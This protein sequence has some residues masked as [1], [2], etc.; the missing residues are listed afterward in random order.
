M[1]G[2]LEPELRQKVI[3]EVEVRE[4]F[5]VGRSSVVAGSYVKSGQITR[6]SRIRLIREGNTIYEGRVASL[7]RFKDDVRE[8]QNGYECGVVL[9][10]FHDIQKDDI[11]EVFQIEEVARKL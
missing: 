10:G 3:G 1:E 5:K 7:R 8:V 11:L 9:E 2:L 4:I 6:N